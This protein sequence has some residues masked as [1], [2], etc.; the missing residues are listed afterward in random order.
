ML[1]VISADGSWLKLDDLSDPKHA[2]Y[3][4]I[5]RLCYRILKLSQDN[6][7]KN[8]VCAGY[9]LASNYHVLV[10]QVRQVATCN[11]RTSL[12]THSWLTTRT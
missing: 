7:R 8:Q 12:L 11:V 9:N 4:H 6:Y 1:K 5:F 3:K 2:S 10:I